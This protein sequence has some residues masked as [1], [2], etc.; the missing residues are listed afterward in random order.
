MV[1]ALCVG[2]CALPVEILVDVLRWPA[3][4]LL[5]ANHGAGAFPSL[6]VVMSSWYGSPLSA[7]T[8]RSFNRFERTNSRSPSF[9]VQEHQRDRFLVLG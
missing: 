3:F 5:G 2:K 9:Q 7:L 1:V 6:P 4:A 8:L